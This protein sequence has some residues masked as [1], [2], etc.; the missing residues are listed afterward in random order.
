MKVVIAR[1]AAADLASIVD[2]IAEREPDRAIPFVV[3]LQ[4][5]CL[6]LGEYPRA[7]PVVPRFAAQGIRRRVVGDYLIF[8]RV[9]KTEVEVLRVLHGARDFAVLLSGHL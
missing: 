8:Y 6:A 9:K 4:G 2:W 7:Y 5:K 3:D 1:A